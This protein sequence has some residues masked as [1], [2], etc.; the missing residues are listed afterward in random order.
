MAGAAGRAASG[1]VGAPD[2]TD[3]I[4]A[5]R[6]SATR[7]FDEAFFLND[8]SFGV[9]YADRTKAKNQF[10]SNLWLPGNISH[11][12]V[13]EQY[14]HRH[15]RLHVSSAARTA[16][17]ATTRSAMYRER[18]LAADQLDRRSERQLRTIAST[19]S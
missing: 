16:S 9:N 18:F 1:F 2:I 4:K 17:S 5:I 11:A 19:M 10:Q 8:V 15:R 7:K 13:P 12:V 3:E 6:L 14:P